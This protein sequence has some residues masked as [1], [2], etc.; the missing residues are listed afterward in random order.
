MKKVSRTI[1]VILVLVVFA[2]S[3]TS[4][5]TAAAIRGSGDAILLVL[6]FPICPALDV[7][8]LPIQLIVWAISKK[9]PWDWF[10]AY[11]GMENQIYLVSADH[12]PFS[13]YY[14]LR[15]KTGSL[16]ETELASL[17]QNLYS[18]PETER[19]AS[20][21][22]LTSLSETRRDF[23]IDAYNSLPENEIV[24]SIKR[25]NALTETERV[26]LLRAFNSLSEAEL[27]S[28]MEELKSLS[29]TEYVASVDYFR[30]KAY[31][32]IGFQY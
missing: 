16:P 19:N 1:A 4:C 21:D 26:S 28:L 32:G 23:L 9:A 27:D 10:S 20:I 11:D 15:D 29:K 25:I 24:S 14:S 30:E 6:P 18:I 3:F 8:T 22:K 2:G 17:K 12:N 13:E 7:V 31:M 5:F